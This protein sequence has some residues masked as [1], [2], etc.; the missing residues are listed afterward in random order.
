MH[1]GPYRS[2]QSG[3]LQR[4]ADRIRRILER[5][6]RQQAGKVMTSSAASEPNREPDFLDARFP[7]GSTGW[8]AQ[9]IRR[10]LDQEEGFTPIADAPSSPSTGSEIEQ[11]NRY[12]YMDL[13]WD[14]ARQLLDG[15]I[16]VF[17]AL[18]KEYQG[19]VGARAALSEMVGSQLP[20]RERGP[21][22]AYRHILLAAELTRRFGEQ[23]AREFLDLHEREGN[24]RGQPA[25]EY[26]MDL[27]NNEIGIRIGTFARDFNDVVSAARKVISGSTV[28]GSGAWKSDY[29]PT[30]TLAP[31][32]ARW[33]PEDEWANNPKFD[34]PAGQAT[35]SRKPA[36]E[37][38]TELTNW[39]SNPDRPNGPD[40]AGGYVADAYE[41]P[42][43][44]PQ[45]ATGSGD[46]N[47]LRAAG[48]YRFLV[49]SPCLVALKEW[50]GRLK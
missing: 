17:E 42:Y 22:D 2:L 21:A 10:I 45:H 18:E 48:A 36:E 6:E 46:A 50:L 35:L 14:A 41:Y 30:S 47:M 44:A 20:G 8:A 9:K 24:I 49:E 4:A 23:R 16:D 5:E 37:M 3:S 13:A 38:P 26:A 31:H 29:D 12:G 15:E 11:D 7:V 39:Y 33:L 34:P 1:Q 19:Y 25:D 43:P 28:D 32:A 27:N 40:W